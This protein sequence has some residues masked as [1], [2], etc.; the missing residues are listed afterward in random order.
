MAD[1]VEQD[2]AHDRLGAAVA[3][4]LAVERDVVADPRGLSVTPLPARSL[5]HRKNR[6]PLA[7]P[8]LRS[9]K[10]RKSV[11]RVTPVHTAMRNSTRVKL[12]PSRSTIRC[13]SQA[14]ATAVVKSHGGE[15]RGK[16][17]Q[18]PA[19]MIERSERK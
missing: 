5:R 13:R 19:D 1:V 14:T 6:A 10:P 8:N 18:D 3:H 17:K 9:G 11:S 15:R 2:L 4:H 12:R 16:P 7:D